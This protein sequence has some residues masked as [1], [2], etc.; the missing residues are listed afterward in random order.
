MYS[1]PPGRHKGCASRR[2]DTRG[3]RH[4]ICMNLPT[5]PS[6][7]GTSAPFSRLASK[8][9]VR[10]DPARRIAVKLFSIFVFPPLTTQ[11]VFPESITHRRFNPVG[12]PTR[13]I[14]RKL[15]KYRTLSRPIDTIQ[16]N[17]IPIQ[18]SF[19]HKTGAGTPAGIKT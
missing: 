4:R 12:P 6:K 3:P 2:F 16:H 11:T 7:A 10:A 15:L 1:R 17:I 9:T 13:D 8:K 19:D 14:S 18:L 5:A